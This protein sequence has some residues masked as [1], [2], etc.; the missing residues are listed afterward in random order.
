MNIIILLVLALHLTGFSTVN[1]QGNQAA[2]V[3]WNILN[4]AQYTEMNLMDNRIA[5][6]Y[7]FPVDSTK[8]YILY[9]GGDGQAFL[10]Y[11]DEKKNIL[12]YVN[13]DAAEAVMPDVPSDTAYMTVIMKYDNARES[14]LLKVDAG[15]DDSQP[16]VVSKKE[17]ICT[18]GIYSSLKEALDNIPDN[19]TIVV[20]PGVYNEN[21]RAWKKAVNIYGTDKEKCVIETYDSSYYNP[22]LE[23]A[24][25]SV[26][27]MTIKARDKGSS[28]SQ[29]K[30]YG[31]HVES[32]LLY[33]SSL[34][35]ENCDIS[36]DFN[37]A[38][39]IGL[40][41][42]C[43]VVFINVNMTGLEYGIFCHDSAYSTYSGVQNITLEGCNLYA[44]TGKY[45]ARFDSQGVK[46]A[47]VN[48]S[49]HN[50]NV[51]EADDRI[52][53]R[54]NGGYGNDDNWRGLKNYYLDKKIR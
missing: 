17:S 41:G 11:S 39:G 20:M 54:N 25:G 32:H 51:D 12:S 15:E 29:L 9:A 36:S 30:A 24:A 2:A 5:V 38:V 8:E 50:N 42:G 35:I 1:V 44:Q 21:V 33:N 4:K 16:A 53:V 47:R 6:Y 31:I 52:E 48:I 37:S 3:E 45:V 46:N 7:S 19:G 34:I 23:I 13:V 22:P 27:N 49:F 14:F 18:K 40:R 28:L 10:I 26:K 43:D